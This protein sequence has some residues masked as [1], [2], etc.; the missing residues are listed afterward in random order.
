MNDETREF[1]RRRNLPHVEVRYFNGKRFT[2]TELSLSGKVIASK[3]T[4]LKRGKEDKT[5]Y[6]LPKI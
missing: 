1:N 4:T 5:T 3:I 6:F 2:E